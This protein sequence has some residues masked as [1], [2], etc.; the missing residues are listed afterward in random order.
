[1]RG[2]ETYNIDNFRAAMSVVLASV[3]YL[4]SAS[5][6]AL[7]PVISQVM[8]CLLAVCEVERCHV[9]VM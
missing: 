9:G 1:M 2:A 8:T 4:P 6:F 5:C 3:A 7:L